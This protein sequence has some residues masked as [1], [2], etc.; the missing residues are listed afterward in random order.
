M[1]WQAAIVDDAN[2]REKGAK[3]GEV[4][5]MMQRARKLL[6]SI[7]DMACNLCWKQ[8]LSNLLLGF[9]HIMANSVQL[10][11]G[12]PTTATYT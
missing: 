10:R 9:M 3:K 11:L 1:W 5:P 4:E 8:F 2:T 7:F 12:M 6:G